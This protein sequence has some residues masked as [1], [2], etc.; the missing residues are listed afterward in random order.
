M[1]RNKRGISMDKCIPGVYAI[2]TS[3]YPKEM[4]MPFQRIITSFLSNI[5]KPF[6]ELIYEKGGKVSLAGKIL[7]LFVPPCPGAV[8]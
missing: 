4:R 6:D 3:S 2:G 8:Q 5:M 7:T 1:Q